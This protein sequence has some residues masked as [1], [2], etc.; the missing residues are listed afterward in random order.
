M[1]EY[2]EANLQAYI[3]ALSLSA[4][5]DSE[6]PIAQ[7]V[8]FAHGGKTTGFYFL[9]LMRVLILISIHSPVLLLS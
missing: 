5:D 1:L 8:N 3:R 2:G 7:L 9:F 6:W 4:P